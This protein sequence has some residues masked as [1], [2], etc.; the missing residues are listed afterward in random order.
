MMPD[1]VL[2]Q[3]IGKDQSD[4]GKKKKSA[5]SVSTSFADFLHGRSDGTVEQVQVCVSAKDKDPQC[6][7]IT[8]KH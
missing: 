6:F 1:S 8:S 4:N 7:S 3:D 2:M 5:S